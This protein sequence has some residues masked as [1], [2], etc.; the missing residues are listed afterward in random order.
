MLDVCLTVKK[1]LNRYGS[2]KLV[3]S[4][5]QF[6]QRLNGGVLRQVAIMLFGHLGRRAAE[7]RDCLQGQ[8]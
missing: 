4:Q 2:Y 6:S 3:A 5:R 7:L 8:A 1:R